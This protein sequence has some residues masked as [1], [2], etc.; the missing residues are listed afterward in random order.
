M[1]IHIYIDEQLIDLPPNTSVAFTFESAVLGDIRSRKVSHTNSFK[2]PK[3]FNNRKIYEF[4]HVIKANGDTAYRR[5]S[6]RVIINGLTMMTGVSFLKESNDGYQISIFED[7]V[8][9]YDS[10]K[11]L[12]LP[13]LDFGGGSITYNASYIDSRRNATSGIVTPAI[14]YGQIDPSLVNAEIGSFYPPS[15]YYKTILSEIFTDVG[16]SI[17]FPS[18][19]TDK[20]DEMILAYS[21]SEWQGTT[22][23]QQD[24]L[25]DINQEDFVK[26]YLIHFGQIL[27]YS[28]TMLTSLGFEDILS[29]RV[30]AIDWTEKRAKMD[31]ERITFGTEYAQNNYFSHFDDDFNIVRANIQV[32]N[33]NLEPEDTIYDSIFGVSNDILGGQSH[34][35]FDSNDNNDLVYGA[36]LGLWDNNANATSY[37]FDNEPKPM[38]LLI[39][40]K[41]AAEP[42][43]LYNGN[44]R[45]DYK[46]GYW[47][48]NAADQTGLT[49]D[50]MR[51]RSE[52]PDVSGFLNKYYPTFETSLNRAKTIERFYYLTLLDIANLDLTKLIFD[53]GVYYYINKIINFVPGKITKVELFKVS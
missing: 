38:V 24:I 13:D 44:S 26:D 4:A 22:F 23:F 29:D 19:V 1:R 16:Y 30:H 45:T 15:I 9:F 32:D 46:V 2:I 51:W 5:Q 49:D 50:S 47:R 10:I 3:S 52:A 17:S 40:D 18:T 41:I 8:D 36:N 37:E 21:R 25:P 43:I 7:I 20:L 27:T 6:A 39:R 12:S 14:N 34:D 48:N 28:G 31:H 11:N 42:A 33:D 53:D 35:E